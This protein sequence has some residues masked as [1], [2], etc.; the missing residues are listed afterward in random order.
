MKFKRILPYALLGL[1]CTGCG[2]SLEDSVEKLGG[3]SEERVQARQELLLAKDRS[4][5]PLLDA[6]HDERFKEARPELVDVLV[7]LMMREGDKRI[8]QALLHR[9]LRGP[10]VERGHAHEPHRLGQIEA[11]EQ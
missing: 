5:R 9:R 7:G 8:E 11:A 6:L 1:L 4:V 2:P 3:S 10:E